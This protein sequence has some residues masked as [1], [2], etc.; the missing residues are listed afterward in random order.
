MQTKISTLTCVFA[1]AWSFFSLFIS[2]CTD[3]NLAPEPIPIVS[4]QV[5]TASTAQTSCNCNYTVPLNT[6]GQIDGTALGIKPGGVVCLQGGGTYKNITFKNFKGT[7][8]SPI[9]IRNCNGSVVL[10]CSGLAYGIRITASSFVRLTGGSGSERNLIVDGGHNGISIDGLSTNVE[11]DHVEVKNNGFAGIMAKTD[12][13]CDDATIRGRFVMRDVLLHDNFVHDTQGEGFYV[14]NSFWL[15]GMSLSCGTRYPHE[16]VGLKIYNNVVTNAGWEAI[17][18]GSTPQGALVYNNRIDNYGR[19]N[20]TAQ[21]NGIQFGEGAN[22]KCYGNW[23]QG[24]NGTG[25]FIAGNSENIVYDNVIINAGQDAIFCDDR[26]NGNG[27]KFINN[28]IINPKQ[29]GIKLYADQVL[30]NTIVNNII[31]NPG[32]YTK[33][34]YPRTASDAYVFKLNNT[35]KVTMSNNW[36]STDINSVKFANAPAHNYALTSASTNVINKGTAVSAFGITLDY[37]NKPRLIGAGVDIGAFE[38][39]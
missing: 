17:Q 19:L 29:N 36:F 23:I 21:N 9:T 1:L 28:T 38:Y 7:A 18:V 12:P 13:N 2:G 33:L 39:Q 8:A 6:N 32:N 25:I 24:G 34:T 4:G 16:I 10:K 30:M 31:I 5:A 27:F 15:K 22:G 14:G 26:V 3:L 11:V 37:A 20:K 35:V